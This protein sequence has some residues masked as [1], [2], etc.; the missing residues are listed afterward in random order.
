[1]NA[2]EPKDKAA[3][4]NRLW[5][6]SDED[7]RRARWTMSRVTLEARRRQ[8]ANLSVRRSTR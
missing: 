2:D 3:V 7:R 5:Q 8:Q 1:M 4:M 6:Y